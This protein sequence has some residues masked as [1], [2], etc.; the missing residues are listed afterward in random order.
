M[1][2]PSG[3][4]LAGLGLSRFFIAVDKLEESLKTRSG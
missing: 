3:L 2:N 1:K 4:A